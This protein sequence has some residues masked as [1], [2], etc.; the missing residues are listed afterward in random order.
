MVK[1]SVAPTGMERQRLESRILEVSR[2]VERLREE[3]RAYRPYSLEWGWADE[4][5]YEARCELRG[6][7]RVLALLGRSWECVECGTRYG[8]DW[9]TAYGP[10]CDAACEG[11]L[12][13]V[14]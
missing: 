9:I 4:A 8:G 11:R 10:V 5:L 14:A 1:D 7:K 13:E 12:E 3:L 6:L 2:R